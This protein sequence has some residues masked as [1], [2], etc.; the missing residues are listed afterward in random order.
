MQILEIMLDTIK[1][2]NNVNI[3]KQQK[4]WLDHDS[5]VWLYTLTHEPTAFYCRN[6]NLHYLNMPHDTINTRFVRLEVRA[7]GM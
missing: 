1:S 5:N 6:I 4:F 2:N 7:V 3:R